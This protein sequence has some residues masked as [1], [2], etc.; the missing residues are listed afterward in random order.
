M[1]WMYYL[2]EANLYLAVFYGF[3]L[4]LLQRETFYQINRYYLLI[5]SALAFL[6]PVFQIGYLNSLFNPI[7][8][9]VQI[10][11]PYSGEL[12]PVA[13]TTPTLT[14][15]DILLFCYLL[16][17]G[18]LLLRLGTSLYR[19]IRM[20][21]KAD[22]IRIGN[23]RK[24]HFKQLDT[25]FSFF[26]LLF[27][28]PDTDKQNIIL[29]H[30]MIHIKQ[31]HSLD[32]LFFETVII[33]NWFNPICWLIKKDIKLIHEY[34]ADESTTNQ[35]LPKHDYAMFLIHNS[36]GSFHNPLASQMFNQS[37]LKNRI[38]MLNKTKSSGR[39][40]L[41]LLYVLPIMA[42][43][44]CTST[45]AFTKDYAVIDLYSKKKEMT[46][47]VGTK[48]SRQ[49]PK[50]G[51]K[52]EKKKSYPIEIQ[53]TRPIKL[54]V[55]NGKVSTARNF[56]SVYDYDGVKELNG[57]EATAK[58]GK[59]ASKGALEFTGK[60]THISIKFPPPIPVRS[61]RKLPTPPRPPL[62][63]R[64]RNIKFPPPIVKPM[65]KIEEHPEV[66]GTDFQS[67]TDMGPNPLYINNGKITIVNP[68]EGKTVRFK[69]K[70]VKVTTKNNT[71][72]IAKY[73][74]S[75]RDGVFELEDGEFFTKD[76]TT[77]K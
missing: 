71:A 50:Q 27:I 73:G 53:G 74:E 41:R 33:L 66:K 10:S 77:K 64:L 54:V 31:R 59:R 34:I 18:F 61:A 24:L 55:I 14:A 49:T 44:L 8:N 38:N 68:G 11:I 62:K 47:T 6:M 65:E 40:R 19:I 4:L 12:L 70:S 75:A 67:I 30:E 46:S 51:P 72:A 25:A 45:L 22:K 9:E 26:N 76:T 48:K 23:V 39:A 36:F 21:L 28:N 37:I 35:G 1:N 42:G 2:L 52:Q 7:V 69:A 60:N 16:V 29:Q 58:Y 63:P 32:I 5:S 13:V 56:T 57:N 3:Y 43:M 15:G 17:A 20:A